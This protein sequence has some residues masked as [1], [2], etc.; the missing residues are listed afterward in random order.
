MISYIIN[1]DLCSGNKTVDFKW[2]LKLRTFIQLTFVEYSDQF[3]FNS[4]GGPPVIQKIMKIT[5]PTPN[6]LRPIFG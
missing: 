3:S 1:I 2:L 6:K 5:N 4:L